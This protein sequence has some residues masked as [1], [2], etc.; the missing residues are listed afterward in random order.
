MNPLCLLG[1]FGAGTREFSQCSRSVLACCLCV[2]EFSDCSLGTSVFSLY[3]YVEWCV[4]WGYLS[5]KR[6]S[7]VVQL[8]SH[9]SFSNTSRCHP[10]TSRR[11][12]KPLIT[13]PHRP[14]PVEYLVHPKAFLYTFYLN[15]QK[16]IGTDFFFQY[17]TIHQHEDSL[18][19]PDITCDSRVSRD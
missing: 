4:L 1:C 6:R 11:I 12:T 18:I 17:L 7:I 3:E 16:S 9:T 5:T 2:G 19:T 14:Y 15:S 10:S 8:A 13:N